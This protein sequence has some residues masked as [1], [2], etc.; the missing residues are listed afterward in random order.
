MDEINISVIVPIYNVQDYLSQCI[1]SLL[2]QTI[3]HEIILIDDGSTDHSGH[4]ADDYAMKDQRIKVIH[5]SNH[6]LPAARN[7][8]LEIAK[9]EYIAFVDSDDYIKKDSLCALYRS[10]HTHSADITI[11]NAIFCR[12]DG[13]ISSTSN[14]ISES[15][16]HIQLSGKQCFK[17]LMKCGSYLPKVN[18][19]IYSREYL[20]RMKF[21]F[22]DVLHEDELW[23]PVVLIQANRVV[24][25]DFDF[26]FYR[27]R[28]DSIVHTTNLR[29]KLSSLFTIITRLIEFSRFRFDE[30][31]MEMK[32]WL[33]VK[34]FSLY[35]NAFSLLPKIKDSSIVVPEFQMGDFW[36]NFH[37]LPDEVKTHCQNYYRQAER[38]MGQY[39]IWRRSE[40][41]AFD[42]LQN[43]VEKKMILVYHMMQDVP[44]SISFNDIPLNYIITTDRKYLTQADVV[45]FYLPDLSNEL[46]EDIEK[47]EGQIWVAW[48]AEY[49]E[50]SSWNNEPDFANLFDLWI[51]YPQD[52]EKYHPFIRLCEEIDKRLAQK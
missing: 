42:H 51:D 27:L 33:Y 38:M 1:D 31:D 6:G 22:E 16:Q 32:G 15:T 5:Q 9:G 10:I 25:T 19:Y 17:F 23:T 39:L 37:L 41:V 7:A 8:G 30:K 26:Y 29:R 52:V 34:I 3:N 13:S 46:E 36:K 18:C 28:N 4:I 45:V 40:W 14:P 47:S 50:H 24:I 11:G 44:Q 35:S 2:D 20:K 49:F 21:K 48:D 43:F 12:S